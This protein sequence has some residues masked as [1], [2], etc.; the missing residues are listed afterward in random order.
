MDHMHETPIEGVAP[1][2]PAA[3]ARPPRPRIALPVLLFVVTC[4]STLAANGPAYALAVMTTL[5]AH[6]LG[7]FLQAL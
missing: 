5:L 4:Y 7:H 6:E 1:T 2:Q 3:I